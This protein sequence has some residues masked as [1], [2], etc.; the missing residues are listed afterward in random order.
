M[1]NSHFLKNIDLIPIGLPGRPAPEP[2][3]A[4]PEFSF[5]DPPFRNWEFDVAIRTKDPVVIRGNL[6]TG[7]A[8]SHLQFVRARRARGDSEVVRRGEVEEGAPFDG[9]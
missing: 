7:G 9:A 3:S 5:P 6:A 8:N 4:R 2:P 1:T